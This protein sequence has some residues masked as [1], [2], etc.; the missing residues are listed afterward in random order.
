[1]KKLKIAVAGLGRIGKIHLNNLLQLT[2][3]EVIGVMDPASE[4][5]EYAKLKGVENTYKKFNE[6]VTIDKLDAIVICT[7]TNTHANYIETSAKLGIQ[8]FCEKPLDLNIQRVKDVLKVV[9]KSKVKLMIGFNRRFDNEFRKVKT[10]INNGEIG[11]PHIVKITSRDPSPPPVEYIKNSGGLFLDMT[12]HDFDMARFI[13]D[14]EIDEIYVKGEAL[15]DQ[16]IQKAGDIDTAVV[17]MKYVDSTLAVIDNSRKAAYGYDQRIEVFGSKGMI[18]V[19]NI[20]VDNSKLYNQNGIISSLPMDFFLERY[21]EAYKIEI[22]DFVDSV[23]NDRI[24]SV[25]GI[26]GLKSLQIVLAA[27]KSLLENRAVK[28]NEIK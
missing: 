12:I 6:L 4:A 21:M 23:I 11:N 13:V 28:I 7:P 27:K 3:V 2:N 14:K 10:S 22:Q 9:D 17:I 26:D 25:T 19:N 20:K 1:M 24:V 18:Q 5:I 16:E 15:I 8:I